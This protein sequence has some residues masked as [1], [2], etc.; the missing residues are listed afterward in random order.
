MEDSEFNKMVFD[1]MDVC[2]SDEDAKAMCQAVIRGKGVNHIGYLDH[3][4]LQALF[5]EVQ[6]MIAEI[7]SDD[8]ERLTR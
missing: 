5:D 1:L 8:I 2:R 7:P 3:E 6:G 4:T